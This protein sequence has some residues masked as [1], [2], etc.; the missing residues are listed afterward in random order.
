MLQPHLSMY[1]SSQV[2]SAAAR[3]LASRWRTLSAEKTPWTL[4]LSGGSAIPVVYQA[5]QLLTTDT[6]LSNCSVRLIDERWGTALHPESNERAVSESGLLEL[7]K[8]LGADWRGMLPTDF[9]IKGSSAALLLDKEY[10]KLQTESYTFLVAGMG[11]DAHT[12]GILPAISESHNQPRF[13]SNAAVVYY[14]LPEDYPSNPFHQRLTATPHFIRAMR[15]VVLYAVG[16]SKLSALQTLLS[17]KSNLEIAH[18][19][20]LSLRH[21]HTPLTVFTDQPV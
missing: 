8:K 20:V 9:H 17:N 1:H 5:L 21:C 7:L 10:T 6:Q 2:E 12:A 15:E 11:A 13:T 19:P 18:F 16:S 14:E 4:F 3:H